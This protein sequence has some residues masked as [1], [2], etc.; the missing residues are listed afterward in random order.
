MQRVDGQ[1]AQ[2]EG[3]VCGAGVQRLR[4]TRL[5]SCGILMPEGP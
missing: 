4:W 1:R 2:M 3:G 5:H